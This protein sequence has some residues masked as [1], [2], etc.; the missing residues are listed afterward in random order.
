MLCVHGIM[1]REIVPDGSQACLPLL[2]DFV[3]NG[4]KQE[5]IRRFCQC[6]THTIPH[7]MIQRRLAECVSC[8]DYRR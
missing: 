2:D 7:G 4:K 5:K 6:L 8:V 3:K 1:N